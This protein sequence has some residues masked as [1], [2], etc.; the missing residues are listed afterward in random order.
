MS[1]SLAWVEQLS[2]CIRMKCSRPSK[3]IWWP[4]I[5]N[6][7]PVLMAKNANKWAGKKITLWCYSFPWD[8]EF[9]NEHRT[10]VYLFVST[11]CCEIGFLPARNKKVIGE[12]AI[13]QSFFS[14]HKF[15]RRLDHPFNNFKWRTVWNN[16]L[17]CSFLSELIPLPMILLLQYHEKRKSPSWLTEVWFIFN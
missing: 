4:K 14:I 5:W 2:K 1:F 9:I 6:I 10:L 15:N 11:C 12:E 13:K 17:G 16:M 7:D 8:F 3:L